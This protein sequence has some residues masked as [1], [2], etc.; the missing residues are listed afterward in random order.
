MIN[1][2]L[3]KMLQAV[4]DALLTPLDEHASMFSWVDDAFFIC[5]KSL[6]RSV[7]SNSDMAASATLNKVY[8]MCCCMYRG[9]YEAAVPLTSVCFLHMIAVSAPPRQARMVQ[10]ARVTRLRPHQT[11]PRAH[12]TLAILH[13]SPQ[14]GEPC[15]FAAAPVPFVQASLDAIVQRTLANPH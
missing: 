4:R 5:K 14:Q 7:A 13:G 3:L 2:V 10:P 6:A 11:I 9:L 8:G 1:L 12:T 15:N